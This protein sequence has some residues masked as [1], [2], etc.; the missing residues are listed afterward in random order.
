[1]QHEMI[2]YKIKQKKKYIY[3]YTYIYK[4]RKNYYQRR[5]VNTFKKKIIYIKQNKVFGRLQ[6]P[7]IFML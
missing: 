5:C 7:F 6:G 1:M 3:I 2:L 4:T